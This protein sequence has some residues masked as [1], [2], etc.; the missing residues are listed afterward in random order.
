MEIS[1]IY[2]DK[3]IIAI[4]KPAGLLTHNVPINSKN[5]GQSPALTDWLINRYPEIKTVGDDPEN[6]P[7][8][9]H[10]LDKE[11]S[12]VIIVARNQ[13]AFEY[14]KNLFQT[15]QVKKTYLGLVWG[16]VEPKS[17]TI[18]KPI[19]LKSGTTKRT[20]AVK[21]AK[22]VKEA[23]TDYQVKKYFDQ[24]SLLEIHPRT[25]RTHQ[26]RVHLNSI[27]HPIVGDRLYGKKPLPA[28]LTRQ[29]LHAASIELNLPDNGRIKLEANL[30]AD[31]ELFLKSAELEDSQ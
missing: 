14:L 4:N 24:Y 11:T 13:K 31:L 3:N 6:R 16:K 12:G 27:H 23:I 5:A 21:N 29:F 10:R 28:G 19:G 30:P 18:N 20:V 26:I 1:V 7:G 2:E 25:G 15:S 9:V 22:M 17:G 8:I